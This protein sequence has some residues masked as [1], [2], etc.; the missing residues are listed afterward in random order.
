MEHI[1]LSNANLTQTNF[2]KANLK[3]CLA[4]GANFMRA[5]AEGS[6]LQTIIT[7][8]LLTFK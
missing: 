4:D 8:E 7:F 1:I 2:S 6:D 3:Q 5:K